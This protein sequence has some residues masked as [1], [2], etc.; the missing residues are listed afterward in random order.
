MWRWFALIIW[1]FVAGCATAPTEVE[2]PEQKF[3]FYPPPPNE[4]RLQFLKKF[5]TVLDV[6]AKSQGMRSFVF[7]GEQFEDRI[8]VKGYGVA[9]YD[10]AIFI[11]DTRGNGYAVIDLE[12]G[13]T[14]MI[15]GSGSGA[16]LKPIN[17]SIDSEGTRYVTDTAR[18]L[19]L[20][21]DRNNRFVRA[22]GNPG[23]FT[24]VDIA[25][26]GDRL[27]VTDVL[28]H[29]VK[30]LN[31]ETGNVVLTF[32][33]AGSEPGQFFHP[34][35]IALGPDETLYITDTSNSRVQHF[36]LEGEFI[37]EIGEIGNVPGKF[38]RPKG[39]S[40]DRE[41]RI[42]V[43]DA[44]FSNVQVLD[45]DG[46][47]LTFFGTPPPGAAGRINL[48]TVVKIDYDNVEYFRRYAA[49]G[50]EIEYLVLVVS[51]FGANR[52]T[53]FGFGQATEEFRHANED[54]S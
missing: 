28:N 1:V 54:D 6:S 27:Y 48:P 24:P 42:Y 12:A 44:A 50:F 41:G 45:T 25:I 4:P 22:L 17:I 29:Q 39:I 36:T 21:F 30:V 46:A 14:Q 7:G 31:K 11:V 10:G 49:T 16:M 35:N 37:R 38:A 34:S 15:R 19:I 8:V 32:G 20:V 40:L 5:T 53:V 2:T 51:Q 52:L 26:V 13:K 3:V 9:V 23:E 47:P 18:Q 43:S 33:E